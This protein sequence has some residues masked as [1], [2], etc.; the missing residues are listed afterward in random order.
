[1]IYV[2]VGLCVYLFLG[3]LLGL[4][5]DHSEMKEQVPYG[6]LPSGI[7]LSAIRKIMFGFCIMF[8]VPAII[9][10]FVNA[11]IYEIRFLWCMWRTKMLL[12]KV[13]KQLGLNFDKI[14]HE[15]EELKREKLRHGN[16]DDRT[17]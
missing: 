6:R 5:I 2:D 4:F 14:V 3:L 12:R 11:A 16:T 10:G 9:T 8:G 1:M 15:M 7:P 13:C 17:S